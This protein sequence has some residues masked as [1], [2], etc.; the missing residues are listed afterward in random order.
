MSTAPMVSASVTVDAPLT[1]TTKWLSDPMHLPIWTGFFQEVGPADADGWHDAQT[2][3]GAIK[4]RI[5]PAETGLAIHSVIKDRD[6]RALIE[7]GEAGKGTSVRFTV[8]LVGEVPPERI[9]A[10]QAAMEREL[11]NL[12][13]ELA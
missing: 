13:T 9:T 7:L 5:E 12:R 2:L 8:T 10:Q 3:A 1:E 11:S 6:E 4:T